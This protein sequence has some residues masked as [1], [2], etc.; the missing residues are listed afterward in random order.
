[1]DDLQ[2]LHELMFNTPVGGIFEYKGK[3]FMVNRMPETVPAYEGSECFIK[4]CCFYHKKDL[5]CPYLRD[6]I[7]V[8]RKDRTS[9]YYKEIG[10]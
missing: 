5:Q 2:K 10:K 3:K 8:H 9:V 4:G 6:C 1:M 7:S